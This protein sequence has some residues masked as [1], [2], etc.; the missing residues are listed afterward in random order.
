M[1][2]NTP[3]GVQVYYE[4]K[5]SGEPLFLLHGWGG[6]AQGLRP[7]LNHFSRDYRVFAFDLPG[8]GRSPAPQKTWGSCQY[9]QCIRQIQRQLNIKNCHVIAHSFGGRVAVILAS[10]YPEGVNKLVLTGCAGLPPERGVAYYA[11]VYLFK[12][13]KKVLNLAGPFGQKIQQS[14]AGRVGSADYNS[15]GE[16]MRAILVNVVNED[17]TGF[18]PLIKAPTLLVWGE[19]DRA[20]PLR[21]GQVMNKLIPDSR[22]VVYPAAG[23]FAYLEK[24]SGFCSAATDFFK[25]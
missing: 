15:A 1:L 19:E 5:G 17:L 7:L 13:S 21:M 8:F 18:L 16:Q 3:E 9:A 12:F 23:H 24:L 2:I 20:T 14:I 25:G 10:K 22:L 6:S 11:K 4:V